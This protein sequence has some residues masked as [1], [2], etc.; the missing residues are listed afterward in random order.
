[1]SRE[2][3]IENTRLNRGFREVGASLWM[4]VAWTVRKVEQI[5]G[6]SGRRK[7]A[8]KKTSHRRRKAKLTVCQHIEYAIPI[9]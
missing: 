6:V 3:L 7:E 8:A 4:V 1:M 5:V 9:C 2:T